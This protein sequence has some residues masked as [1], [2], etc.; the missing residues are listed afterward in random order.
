MKTMLKFALF[1]VAALALASC[2]PPTNTVTNTNT[3]T[4]TA[5][6]A[7]VPTAEALMV[8]ENK[9]WEAYK[10]KDAKFFEGFLAENLISGSGE[11]TMPR[12]EAVKMITGHSD[13]VKS[14]TLSDP[15]VTPV[16]ADAAVLTYKGVVEGT[17]NGK[18]L[19]SPVT[20]ATVFVRSG[21]DWKA[22]YHNEVAIIEPAKPATGADNKTASTDTNKKA[23]APDT[24][25]AATDTNKAAPAPAADT[26]KAAS[27][28]TAPSNTNSTAPPVDTA[29]TDALMVVEKKGWEGWKAKDAKVLDEVSAQTIAFVDPAGKATFGKAD[30]VKLWTTDNPCNVTSFSLSDA[31]AVSIGKDAAILVVKGTAVGTC[32]D[33]KLEPLWNT[34]VF[35]KEGDAWKV[36]YMLETPVAKS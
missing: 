4:N 19:P 24:N 32:G 13:E 2:A 27:T 28:N 17:Q 3:N 5:P 26:N 23:T 35:V 6:K 20:V 12:A 22:V 16:G 8:L 36:A 30:V 31:K 29:L 15:R 34:S 9:A 21:S 10:N 33:M 7:A 18:A 1:A 14:F 25:K 11:G